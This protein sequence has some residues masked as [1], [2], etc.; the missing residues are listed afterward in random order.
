MIPQFFTAL[1][2]ISSILVVSQL[3][4][5]SEVLVAFGLSIENI[6]FP[7]L[8]I[9][10]P[11]LSFT[12]PMAYL[13]G[14]LIGFLRLSADGEMPAFLAAGFSLGKAARPIV[15]GGFVLFII[16]AFCGLYLE[17][18]GRREFIN[19]YQRKAQGE[20]DN[21]IK[22]KLKSGVFLDDFL[23]YVL[24]AEKISPDKSKF[25]N[26]MMAPG[27]ANKN[28]SFKLFAPKGSLTG[29]VDAADL[30]MVFNDGQIYSATPGS[31]EE[32]ILSFRRAELDLIRIFQN[33]MFSSSS[34]GGIDYRS[35]SPGALWAY[36]GKLEKERKQNKENEEEYKRA[37]FLF[38]QRAATPFASV[39]FS[40][41]ALVLGVTDPRKGKGS[42][43]FASIMTVVVGYLLLMF[44]KWL[45]ENSSFSPLLAA[46]TPNF[47]MLLAAGFALYQKNRLPASE[48]ILHPANLPFGK[49][50]SRS[51]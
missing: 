47:L 15:I 22:Y 7:F 27:S 34:T 3:I 24:Y 23:G 38:H 19:F 51:A 6:L 32:S 31:T 8:F 16:G 50:L 35:L 37:R 13:F 4:R 5:L 25:E 10:L 41:F 44:F 42:A 14:V 36:I 26:L 21:V 49:R 39:F 12:I 43:Y 1:C 9:I 45:A 2:V 33:Q 28:Q 40:I 30:K 46:W 20:L 17:P 48:S 18:W 11:F 29:S